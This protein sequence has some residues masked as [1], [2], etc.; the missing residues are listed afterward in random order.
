MEVMFNEYDKHDCVN[1]NSIDILISSIKSGESPVRLAKSE[2]V[3][4]HDGWVYTPPERYEDSD[5]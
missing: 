5:A 3:D 2:H 1:L 4:Y